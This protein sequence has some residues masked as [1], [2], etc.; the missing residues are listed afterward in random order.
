MAVKMGVKIAFGT[1]A[2]VGPHGANAEELALMVD[3]GMTPAATLRA[4]TAGSAA[5]LGIDKLTGTLE[6]GK[7]A[8]VIAVAGD[9]LA[10]IRQMKKV[11][12]VMKGGK[13]Y[14]DPSAQR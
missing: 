3:H 14:L 5:L 13:L 4:A 9:P 2:A 11:I 1:D 7:E 8:D 12:L 10:D 6:A